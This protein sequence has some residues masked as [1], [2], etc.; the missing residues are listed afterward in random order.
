MISNITI[1]TGTIGDHQ[2]IGLSWLRVCRVEGSR[3]VIVQWL[4][5]V[6]TFRGK[7]LKDVA[8]VCYGTTINR[9]LRIVIAVVVGCL[10]SKLLHV[11]CSVVIFASS[12]GY[13]TLQ[14]WP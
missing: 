4:L 6:E 10:S 7:G 1:Q 9:F 14:L 12:K 3:V 2:L 8:I 13:D 5:L 11:G